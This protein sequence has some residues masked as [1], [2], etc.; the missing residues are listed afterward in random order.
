MRMD[1]KDVPILQLVKV[2]DA[3][4]NNEYSL[5][6]FYNFPNTVLTLFVYSISAIW[7]FILL[8][9]SQILV[10]DRYNCIDGSIFFTSLMLH[11]TKGCST[12]LIRTKSLLCTMLLI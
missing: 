12:Q 4:N 3:L 9:V 7:N 2:P 6:L 10:L 1:F 8:M 11:N 5:G